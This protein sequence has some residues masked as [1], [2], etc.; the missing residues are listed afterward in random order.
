[1][2]CYRSVSLLTSPVY[3]PAS[4][5]YKHR[6]VAT[7]ITSSRNSPSIQAPCPT[8]SSI[9]TIRQQG[10]KQAAICYTYVV[11]EAEG[12]MR[13]PRFCAELRVLTATRG[14]LLNASMSIWMILRTR[15]C[16]RSDG[17]TISR[18]IGNIK[19]V[20][21]GEVNKGCAFPPTLT[22]AGSQVE[23]RVRRYHEGREIR[24]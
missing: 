19:I 10:S 3:G 23:P 7:G 4:P 13:S 17:M 11:P 9:L 21:G 20:L 18:T 1:M 8:G 14:L 24:E 12:Q 16:D 6:N 5:S 15:Q 2:I 22:A